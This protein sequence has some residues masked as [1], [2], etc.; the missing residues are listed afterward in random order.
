MS[1]EH[2]IDRLFQESF[3]DFEVDAPK[4]AWS[5]IEKRLT[6]KS[7]KR[8]IPIWLKF[9]GAAAVIAILIMAGSQ[10][11]LSSNQLDDNSIVDK[12]QENIQNSNNNNQSDSFVTTNPDE[13]EN[14]LRNSSFSSE[15]ENA[16]NNSS[17]NT[18][19]L[20]LSDASSVDNIDKQQ[21][22]DKE[23]NSKTNS[24]NNSLLEETLAY[25]T[26]LFSK[27]LI[28]QPN[29]NI[30]TSSFKKPSISQKKSLVEVAK[31]LNKEK[32][33]ESSKTKKNAWFIKPQVS[34]IF[35]G[36][37]GSGSAVDPNLAQND[38]Q[39]E[40]NMSYGINVAYQINKKIKLRTG[41]NRVNLNYT[42]NDVFLV[43]NQ[44]V[45][46]LNNVNTNPNFTA[47]ILN[48]QQLQNLSANGTFNRSETLSSELQQELGYIEIPME[49]EYKILNR[50]IDINLIGGASTLLLNN[51]N[52]DI[53]NTNGT[54]S[55]GEANN[56]NDL[57]FSTNFAIGLDY[58][59]T[60]RLMFNLEPTFK[61]QFNTFQ[62][63]T[64]DFQPYFLGIYSGVVFK[65]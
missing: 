25:T 3:K 18:N 45:A 7:K 43:Q 33:T 55:V 2:N 11:F 27:G 50:K 64:T 61:Y 41:V 5:G 54:V 9:S 31:N 10:W 26:E 44:G 30:E 15:N 65:F 53:K 20:A 59:I 58:D 51:N 12:T 40:V 14:N 62:G 29:Q 23:N 36:N 38:G 49:I 4:T 13:D 63:G 34:P 8:I 16:V 60:K 46:S 39:G 56:I 35:Y 22:T 32:E 1:D 17:Q 19:N 48:E 47:S 24:Y 6:Q 37:L 28:Q 42:T 57:S 21:D 52:L